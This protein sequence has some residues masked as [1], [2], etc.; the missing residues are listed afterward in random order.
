MAA[1]EQPETDPVRRLLR[2]RPPPAALRWAAAPFGPGSLV[3]AGLARLGGS[4]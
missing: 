2:R 4:S 3:A 1:I